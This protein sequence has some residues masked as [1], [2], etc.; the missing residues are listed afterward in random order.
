MDIDIDSREPKELDEIFLDEGAI[1][2][3][4]VLGVGDVVV[5]DKGFCVERKT[6]SD[7]VGSIRGG[8]IQ[9]QALNMQIYRNR[10][11]IVVGSLRDYAKNDPS[12]SVNHHMGVLASLSARYRVNVLQVRNDIQ[13]VKLVIKLLEKLDKDPPGEFETSLYVPKSPDWRLAVLMCFEGIGPVKAKMLL[14]DEVV[15]GVL[16]QLYIRT[17]SLK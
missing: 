12:W 15:H 6:M 14:E 2:N 5:E 17:Y 11:V 13:F 16:E 10:Y 3:R 7:L 1:P 8:H 9:K 4:K